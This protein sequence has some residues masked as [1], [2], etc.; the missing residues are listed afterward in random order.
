MKIFVHF[1]V[2]LKACEISAFIQNRNFTK[3]VNISEIPRQIFPFLQQISLKIV[4][5]KLTAQDASQV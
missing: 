3:N 5:I 2:S 1:S 4:T